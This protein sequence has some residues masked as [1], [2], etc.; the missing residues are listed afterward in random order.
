[1]F[2]KGDNVV[3]VS[4]NQQAYRAVVVQEYVAEDGTIRVE[5]DYQLPPSQG[6]GIVRA[7]PPA[8]RVGKPMFD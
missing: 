2:S 7:S 3:F 1:M 6:G 8:T 4:A 5:L